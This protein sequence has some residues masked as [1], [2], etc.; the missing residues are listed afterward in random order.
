MSFQAYYMKL[1][2]IAIPDGSWALT[3]LSLFECISYIIASLLGDLLKGRL[4]Y[5]NVVASG[6]LAIICFIWPSVDVNY[7]VILLIAGGESQKMNRR[8]CVNLLS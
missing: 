8:Q 5:A 3:L 4:V 7:T 2:G 1:K 6:C